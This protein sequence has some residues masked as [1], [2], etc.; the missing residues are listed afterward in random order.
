MLPSTAE[1]R[2]VLSQ[3]LQA[4]LQDVSPGVDTGHG[5]LMTAWLVRSRT[6]LPEGFSSPKCLY[7]V[8]GWLGALD[9]TT[10][11]SHLGNNSFYLKV[12][13]LEDAFGQWSKGLLGSLFPDGL[14]S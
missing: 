4:L 9:A 5:V 13:L 11:D 14:G 12:R 7:H 10:G 3:S 6:G 1:P 8:S 2:E